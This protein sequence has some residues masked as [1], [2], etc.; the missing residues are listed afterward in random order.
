MILLQLLQKPVIKEM[1]RLLGHVTSA[2]SNALQHSH[3]SFRK[4]LRSSSLLDTGLETQ[5]VCDSTLVLAETLS[6]SATCTHHGNT[7]GYETNAQRGMYLRLQ[8]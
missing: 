8:R 4:W 1:S 7:Y 5:K 2:S 3:P 6:R